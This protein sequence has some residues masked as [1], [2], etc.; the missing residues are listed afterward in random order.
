MRKFGFEGLRHRIRIFVRASIRPSSVGRPAV[1][2]PD[3]QDDLLIFK[4][5]TNDPVVA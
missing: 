3:Y 4:Q 2:D 1:G 5:F